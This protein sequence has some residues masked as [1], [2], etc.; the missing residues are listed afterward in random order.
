M[1]ICIDMQFNMRA[2]SA[3]Y[4]LLSQKGPVCRGYVYIYIH[5]SICIY[6]YVY[7]YMYLYIYIRMYIHIYIYRYIGMYIYLYIHTFVYI[8]T[9]IHNKSGLMQTHK[10]PSKDGMLTSSRPNQALMINE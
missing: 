5:I 2:V 6:I 8:F 3:C 4:T 9:Y 10:R 1:C 7:I